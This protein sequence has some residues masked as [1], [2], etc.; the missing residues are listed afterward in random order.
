MARL[1]LTAG[2]HAETSNWW[3][4]SSQ[5]KPRGKNDREGTPVTSGPAAVYGVGNGDPSCL[6]ADQPETATK[7]ARSVW[8]G[9][10]RVVLQSTRRAGAGSFTLHASAEGLRG[11]SLEV[12][13]A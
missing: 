4:P 1:R 5:R 11:A 2:S 10:A 3:N 9:L 7:A 8:N 13:T 6:E 12:H